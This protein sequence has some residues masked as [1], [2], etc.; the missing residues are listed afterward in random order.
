ME[1]ENL[2][3]I[4]PLGKMNGIELGAGIN[5]CYFNVDGK[6]T[7]W[8]VTRNTNPLPGF[9]RDWDSKQN[10]TVTIY[11]VHVCGGYRPDKG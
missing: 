5:N 6:C 11:G 7:S 2:F 4:R 1:N 3:S 10:C 8:E 9:V